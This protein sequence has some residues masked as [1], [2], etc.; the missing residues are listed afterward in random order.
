MRAPC[1][2]TEAVLIVGLCLFAIGSARAVGSAHQEEETDRNAMNRVDAQ[3]P[4]AP[5]EERCA[6]P[7]SVV[8]SKM[9]DQPE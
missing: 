3:S 1:T 2:L 9:L 8:R 7:P 6:A 4:D 5:R